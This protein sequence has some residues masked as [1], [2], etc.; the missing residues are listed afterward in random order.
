MYPSSLPLPASPAPTTLA[1]YVAG[2]RARFNAALM[3]SADRLHAA[4]DEHAHRQGWT[5][6]RSGLTGR[7]YRSPLFDGR[8]AR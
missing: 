6:T 8:S 1:G 5:V 7:A 3:S 2:A 4:G